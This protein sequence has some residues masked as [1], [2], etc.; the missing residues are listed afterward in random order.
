MAFN[1]GYG[2]YAKRHVSAADI[3][4]KLGLDEKTI[5]TRVK[6]M[7][8]SGFIKY[9]QVVPN[10]ALFG[11]RSTGS[12][13][14]EALNLATK[15]DVVGR[16]SEIHHLVEGFDYLGNS[17]GATFAGA[18]SD[19]V[20]TAA[21]LLAKRFEL[22]TTEIGERAVRE[23]LSKLDSLDLQIMRELRYDARA[24]VKT[25]AEKLG[26]T[27]RM[28]EYRASKL[29]SSGALLV[30]AVIDM[31]KQAGL[32]FFEL[33]VTTD[34]DRHSNVVRRIREKYGERLWYFTT[35]SP[36]RFVGSFF[37]F[38]LGEPEV[39]ALAIRKI[40]G[41]RTSFPYILK[42]AVEPNKPNWIDGLLDNAI[43]AAS[44][45]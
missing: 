14:F 44:N 23:P 4:K 25:I 29:M 20:G 18:T 11:L 13:R 17:V 33:E 30:H 19:D 12:F 40:D 32:V 42:E 16:F 31:Q 41:V 27:P 21:N 9:Y 15:A 5:R 24:K 43:D 6:R 3:G 22:Y 2:T 34:K 35:P 28:V 26:I 45:R 37:G 8:H 1:S 39:A 36:T 38:S 7:E 10:L